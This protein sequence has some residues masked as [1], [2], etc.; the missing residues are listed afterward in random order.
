LGGLSGLALAAWVWLLA[1]RGGFWRADQRLPDK[2]PEL[3]RWPEVVAV[4]PARNEAAFVGAAVSSLLGQD[5]P[6]RFSV[7]LVDDAS[8]DGTAEIAK[9]AAESAGSA[10]RFRQL[11]GETLPAGWTGKLWAMHQGLAEAAR[12][13][14]DAVYVLLTDADIVHEPAN[15]R[16]LVGHAEGERLHL[17]S[18]MVKLRCESGWEKILIPAFVFFFQKLYPFPWVHDARRRSAA[19]AGGCMLVRKET[20]AAA[21]GVER[22]RGR[23]IDDCALACEI[24]ARGPIWLGLAERTMS[25]RP[26]DRL[27][28]IWRMVARSAFEQLN[29]SIFALAGTLA[30]M[31]ALYVVPPLAAVYGVATGAWPLALVGAAGWGLMAAAYGPTV[32]LYGLVPAHALTLPLAGALYA[33][34]TADSARRHWAGA[35]AGWKGRSYS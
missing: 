17:V 34:M 12:F 35:P 26:Y 10:S 7:V 6:G 25:L 24:K 20:L 16:R 14:P 19:A 15:L 4:V 21:G 1:A 9:H 3:A 22:I 11:R 5:Y 32:R 2:T 33:L 13:A 27:G 28:D 29:R 30:G 31:L 23:L 18:L 8:D